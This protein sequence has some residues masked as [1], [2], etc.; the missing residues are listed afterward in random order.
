M[1]AC[2]ENQEVKLL[3]VE[4]E[5]LVL[6]E[7]AEFGDEGRADSLMGAGAVAP[8]EG[9]KG[10]KRARRRE[11]PVAEGFRPREFPEDVEGF[12]RL[13]KRLG[14]VVQGRAMG[15]S[16][17]DLVVDLGGMKG[18]V[19]LEE[20]GCRDARE[21]ERLVGQH[22]ALVVQRV[23]PGLAVCSRRR[24]LEEMSSQAW[25]RLVPG[26]DVWSVVRGYGRG[27]VLA[28][29][30]GVVA[31]VPYRELS[32]GWVFD[33]ESQF[34]V[35]MEM[36]VRVLSADRERGEVV[37]S[38]KVL[39]PDPWEGAGRRYRAGDVVAGVVVSVTER[40]V[41]VQLEPGLDAYC[42]RPVFQELSRGS[43]VVLRVDHVDAEAKRMR[44]HLMRVLG[45]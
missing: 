20:S 4:A 1:Q 13:A 35:G 8:G 3:V 17:G 42:P 28:D 16:A 43:R 6:E 30:G 41:F 32:R 33:V 2:T 24:A 14:T 10:V 23:Y 36:E 39:L 7:C 44:G 22:V 40:A 29:V 19:S 37:C 25:P 21:L 45:R 15:V 27:G 18:R 38:R 9:K 34:P 11:V 5:E 12:L 26:K 31:L